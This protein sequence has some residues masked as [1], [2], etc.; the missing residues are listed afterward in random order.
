M[1]IKEPHDFQPVKV[2]LDALV[3]LRLAMKFNE[4]EDKHY[5]PRDPSL[6]E[7]QM[8]QECNYEKILNTICSFIIRNNIVQVGYPNDKVD[9]HIIEASVNNII[10]ERENFVMSL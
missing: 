6:N 7:N 3:T 1:T 8:E 2:H 9:T 10:Q 5:K 4:V